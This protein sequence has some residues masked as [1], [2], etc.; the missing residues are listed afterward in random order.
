MAHENNYFFNQAKEPL[1]E[2]WYFLAYCYI[3]PSQKYIGMKLK[4]FSLLLFVATYSSLATAQKYL[5]K[6]MPEITAEWNGNFF[7]STKTLKD[8]LQGA[9]QFSILS[10]ILE[11]KALTESMDQPEMFTA[12]VFTDSSF[13]GLEKKTKDSILNNKPLLV[14][15]VKYLVVPGRIDE[16]GLRKEINKRNGMVFLRTLT[17]QNIGA[18]IHDDKLYLIDSEGNTALVTASN[19]YH[20]KGFFHIV[21]GLVF[22]GAKE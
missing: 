3:Y 14:S 15:M 19:Y 21:E 20:K 8:N 5:N 16:Y 6:E 2:A 1:P 4:I 11:D 22:P 18:N 12:F 7:V 10:S 13:N 9:P 17:G